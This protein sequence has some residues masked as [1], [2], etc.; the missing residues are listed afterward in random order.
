M[1]A[2]GALR[3]FEHELPNCPNY[4][5]AHETFKGTEIRKFE[6]FVLFVFENDLRGWRLEGV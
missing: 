2:D 6:K 1:N 3:G 5:K 4:T